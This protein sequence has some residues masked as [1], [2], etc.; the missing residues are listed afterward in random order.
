LLR[1][2]LLRDIARS[3]VVINYH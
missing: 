3:V 1:T 2:A